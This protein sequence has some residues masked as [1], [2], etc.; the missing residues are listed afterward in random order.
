MPF[1]VRLARH[2]DPR[3][4]KRTARR[5][6]VAAED[7]GG[8]IQGALFALGFMAMMTGA[9]LVLSRMGAAGDASVLA[10][11]LLVR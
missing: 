11:W 9:Y 8:V 7:I 1:N 5:S 3:P 4:P 6:S 10:N 2:D